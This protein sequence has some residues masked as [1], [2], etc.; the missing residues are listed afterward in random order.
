MTDEA[1]HAARAWT[2]MDAQ[3]FNDPA[4]AVDK[5]VPA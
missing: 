4:D 1:M 3:P 5:P 2:V